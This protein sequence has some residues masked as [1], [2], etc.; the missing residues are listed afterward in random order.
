MPTEDWMTVHRRQGEKVAS[1]DFPGNF[2]PI[3]GAFFHRGNTA[4]LGALKAR[5]L[6]KVQNH[7]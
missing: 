2:S 1:T 4:T 3:R 6:P 7:A 5:T